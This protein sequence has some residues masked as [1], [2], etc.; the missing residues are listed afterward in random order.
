MVEE[1]LEKISAGSK[2]DQKTRTLLQQ[3]TRDLSF[4]G[5]QM[6]ERWA[7]L[8][9][10]EGVDLRE[11]PFQVVDF[12]CGCGGMSSGFR[13]LSMEYPIFDVVGG[14][15]ISEDSAAAFSA[16]YNVPAVAKDIREFASDLESL[17]AFLDSLPRFKKSRSTILI[18]CAP[19]QGFTTH[20][21]KNWH[22]DDRRN[23][24]VGEFA[25]VALHVRPECVV[26]ENVP[27]LLSKKYWDHFLAA[28]D[29]LEGGG[30]TVKQ[31]IYNTADFGVPQ[32]RFRALVVAM[33]NDFDLP[34]PLLEPFEH[35]TV[36]DAIGDL[37][38]V[39]PG[40][41]HP[42]DPL[43]RSAAHKSSTL[44]T[45]R[46]VPKD[47][48]S[49]PIGVGP[50]CLDKVNG[51]S[52]V[53]GRLKWDKPAITITHYARNPASGRFVHP[54]QDRGLTLREAARLQSFPDGYI[55]TGSN[56]QMFRQVGEAVP[57]AFS[58]G[59]ASQVL[60]HLLCSTIDSDRKSG[61]QLCIDAP[62]SS[63]FS[64]V[65]VGLKAARD[66]ACDIAL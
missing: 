26:M 51:F 8:S 38:S 29:L 13:A 4:Y 3:G 22:E 65:I 50:K 24:L 6:L 5:L 12:F 53:Y 16:N 23:S 39:N 66:R 9:R 58:V 32:D 41:A 19:C 44:D 25:R 30:Y 48:G 37:P 55:F 27:E 17:D 18:G 47:G 21:K 52:D 54:Q 45:I 14:C 40:V 62:V 7:P 2:I 36:R 46:A 31:T 64:S 28:K 35:K 43:H 34:E 10:P 61:S 20:R 57:P 56:D 63:S 15:D 60:S 42:R 33:R 59:V 1:I 11:E 49:R